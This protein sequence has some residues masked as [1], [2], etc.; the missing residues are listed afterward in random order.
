[1]H[2]SK[3][4]PEGGFQLSVLAGPVRLSSPLSHIP[5][6]PARRLS[7]AVWASHSLSHEIMRVCA[8]ERMIAVESSIRRGGDEERGE[9]SCILRRAPHSEPL[10]GN[11]DAGICR[12]RPAGEGRSTTHLGGM[13]DGGAGSVSGDEQLGEGGGMSGGAT[14]TRGAESAETGRAGQ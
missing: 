14:A 12:G 4:Q 9:H 8:R 13:K 2:T 1:M 6:N 5:V 7:G 3:L 11:D 10:W